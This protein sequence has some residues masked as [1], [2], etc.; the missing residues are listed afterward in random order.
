MNSE[1]AAGHPL[2]TGIGVIDSQHQTFFTI[3]ER[4]RKKPLEDNSSHL[5]SLLEKI[6]L[7][8]L[9]HFESEERIMEEAGVPNLD[10]HKKNHQDFGEKLEEFKLKCIAEDED[11]AQE[12]TDALENWL[13]NHI[14]N[15]D[16]RDLEYVKNNS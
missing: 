9:Y 2:H 4:I 1:T 15:T 13:V 3:L 5:S 6:H 8:T 10:E 16:K 7:Y 12:M 14:Q 11:L